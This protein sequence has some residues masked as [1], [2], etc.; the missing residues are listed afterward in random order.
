[1]EEKIDIYLTEMSLKRL[2]DGLCVCEDDRILIHPPKTRELCIIR[3]PEKC[4]KC[5]GEII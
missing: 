3:I 2:S 4:K 5:C 1:M